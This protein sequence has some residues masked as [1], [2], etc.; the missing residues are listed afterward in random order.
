MTTKNEKNDDTIKDNTDSNT[1]A[2]KT[3]KIAEKLENLNS[4]HEDTATQD[5]NGHKF[6]PLL[7]TLLV[8]IPIAGIIAYINMPESFNRLFSSSNNSSSSAPNPYTHP[9]MTNYAATNQWNRQQ[10]EWVTQQRDD[11]EKRRAEFLKQNA[12]NYPQ[13][14]G[15]M[16][17]PEPPQWV[18]DRQ[19]EM[20]QW[21]KDGK[22]EAPQWVKD[23]QAEMPQWVRDRQA[24]MEREMAKYQQPNT[25]PNN[26]G[27]NWTPEPPAYMQHPGPNSYQQPNQPMIDNQAQAYQNPVNAYPPQG[28]GQNQYNNSYNYPVNPYY[29][30]PYYY[31]PG[32][33]Y[34]GPY[35]WNGYR[36]R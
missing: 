16:E 35:G 27:Y 2:D 7:I 10:P 20:P 21:S 34:Y 26:R 4:K 29:N 24:E 1:N 22:M 36:Y 11:M 13:N 28:Q 17:P 25:Y 33:N 5:N 31:G 14:P 18:K 3:S 9:E 6:S 23:R 12:G 19:A 8:A 15:A 32:P 30:A